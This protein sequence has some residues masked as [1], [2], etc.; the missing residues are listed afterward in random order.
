MNSS[1]SAVSA[2]WFVLG[3]Q[4]VESAQILLTEDGP[5]PVVAFHRIL[6]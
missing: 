5:L 1:G 4:D 6:Y 2:E 3:D